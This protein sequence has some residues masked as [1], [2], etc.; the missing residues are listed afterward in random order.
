[1]SRLKK[2]IPFIAFILVLFMLLLPLQGRINRLRVEKEL[3]ETDIFE[4][5]T[6]SDI[7]GTL[8]L[9]GFRG[10]AVDMLWVQAI[11][12]Q[13]E[14]KF[15]ELLTL[16]QLILD[17]QPHFVNIWAYSAWNMAYNISNDMETKEQKWQW[18]QKGLALLRKGIKRNPKSYILYFELGWFYF[19][20]VEA[21]P[22]YGEQ[23]KKEGKNNYFLALYWFKQ[24]SK[25]EPHPSYVERIIAHTWEKLAARAEREG[26]IEKRDEYR[27]EALR[28]WKK[29]VKKYPHD[30]VSRSAYIYWKKILGKE[31]NS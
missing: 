20:K 28:Q 1:M 2:Y 15:F 16:Y 27:I 3:V 13:Q 22:Y 14:G 8:L 18:I 25:I 12:L 30:K 19:H 7:W 31:N 26:N 17:L 4:T 11:N 10:V 5:T 21:D 24:A 9:A 29:N 6:P 23:L